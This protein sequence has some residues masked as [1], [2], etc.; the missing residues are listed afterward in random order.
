MSEKIDLNAPEVQSAIKAAVEEATKG[1]SDKN[2]EL[3]RELKE[4]RKGRQIDPSELE[5][6]E[7]RIE[8][9]Q[10]EL[11][12][13]QKESKAAKDLA[14][15]ATKDL[16]TEQGFTQRLLVEN[17]LTA[18]LTKNGVTNPAFIKAAQAI[19]AGQAKIIVDGEQRIAKIGDKTLA[20]YIPEWAKSDEG[21][22]FVAAPGNSGGGAGGGGSGGAGGEPKGK[23]DGNDAERAVHFA[24]KYPDLKS[25]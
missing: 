16:Q 20:E 5:K 6:L 25:T 3:L 2:S 19:L 23:I 11:K 4:A 7:E 12:T 14:D 10:G 13:A 9:L 18:E 24:T 21:K 17:G 1:L 22:H 15:K 8:Q